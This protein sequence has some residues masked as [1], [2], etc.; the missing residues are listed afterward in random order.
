MTNIKETDSDLG[1]ISLLFYIHVCVAAVM[2]GK[3]LLDPISTH[4]LKLGCD[5]SK[6]T[7]R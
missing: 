3:M 2:Q 5:W 6:I 4:M 1:Q 7:K